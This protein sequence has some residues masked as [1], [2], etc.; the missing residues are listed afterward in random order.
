[1]SQRRHTTRKRPEKVNIYSRR[2]SSLNRLERYLGENKESKLVA[3]F[4]I[5][6]K[7]ARI[8]IA[9]KTV[10][11]NSDWKREHFFND[12]DIFNLGN[13]LI[14]KSNL[15]V[16]KSV[17]F[18]R[19]IDFM[20]NYVNYLTAFGVDLGNI[21]A[22]GTAVFRWLGNQKEV[23]DKIKAETG[24]NLFILNEKQESILSLYAINY[25]YNVSNN[26]P[27]PKEKFEDDDVILLIDQGGGSTEI[28]YIFPTNEEKLK[29]DSIDSLG[30]VALSNYFF[31]L[32]K[33]G[34]ADPS[35]NHSSIPTQFDRVKEIIENKIN[36][37]KQYPEIEGKNIILYAMGSAFSLCLPKGNN[38]KNHNAV[39]HISNAWKI[40]H[41]YQEK[42][43]TYEHVGSL[44]KEIK[45]EASYGSSKNNKLAILY[46]LPVY[47]ELMAVFDTRKGEIR[48]AGFGLRYGAYIYKYKM[49]RNFEDISVNIFT[50]DREEET[51]KKTKIGNKKA[52]YIKY[53]EQYPSGKYTLIAQKKIDAKPKP[54][55]EVALEENKEESKIM[56]KL[57]TLVADGQIK[58]ALEILSKQTAANQELHK[59]VLTLRSKFSVLQ[60]EITSGTIYSQ[61]KDVRNNKIIIAIYSILDIINKKDTT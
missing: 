50:E 39:M 11:S 12:G 41:L 53:L 49:G 34:N 47:L 20:K 36:N 16:N 4:D 46:G 3:L 35:E 43:E 18:R 48:F 19:I 40:I 54:V 1:M 22:I 58:E 26:H 30:T 9:P 21:D 45:E 60:N 17:A 14:H 27:P 56:V 6:T 55:E 28:S 15:D 33:D 32:G 61:D 37:W 29:V 44:Y 42:Y 31:T 59:E 38:F 57:K 51:W 10:P 7:A 52:D 25:T 13:D 24:I 23:V 2:F 5:G 8:I